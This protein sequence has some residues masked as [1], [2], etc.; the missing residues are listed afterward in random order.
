MKKILYLIPLL[1]ISCE[2]TRTPLIVTKFKTVP[3]GFEYK[4]KSV[5]G[6]VITKII[7]KDK[8]NIGDTLKITK[9][10]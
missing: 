3:E 5:N 9:V 8:F 10:K 2:A 6:P 1:F 4:L 7:T